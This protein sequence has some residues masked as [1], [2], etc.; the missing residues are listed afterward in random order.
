MR[1]P[2]R[3]DPRDFEPFVRPFVFPIEL[4]HVGGDDGLASPGAISE[5]DVIRFEDGKNGIEILDGCRELLLIQL[6][7]TIPVVCVA[8][9]IT[10]PFLCR[11][12]VRF[13]LYGR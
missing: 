6:D 7:R 1:V 9:G 8:D 5:R 12:H 11:V 4:D 3:V 2:F 13:T 10:L